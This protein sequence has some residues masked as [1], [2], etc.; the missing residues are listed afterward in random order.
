VYVP[1]VIFL[2]FWF[3][4]QLYSGIFSLGVNTGGVAWWAHV[5]GFL[6]G[7]AAAPILAPAGRA[8]RRRH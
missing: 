8:R 4:S 1:A 5:G 3:V 7:V 2:G 6:F